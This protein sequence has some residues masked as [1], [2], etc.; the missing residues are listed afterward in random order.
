MGGERERDS[1]NC[2]A[3]IMGNRVMVRKVWDFEVLGAK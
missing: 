3:R 2:S 1:K